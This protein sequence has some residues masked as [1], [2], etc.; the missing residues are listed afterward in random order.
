MQRS[1]ARFL[2]QAHNGYLC[3]CMTQHQLCCR[4]P[5]MLSTVTSP[6]L[7]HYDNSCR[8]MTI[9]CCC[10]EPYMLCLRV[11]N[12]AM[13][14]ASRARATGAL[15][16]CSGRNLRTYFDSPM[17]TSYFWG[18]CVNACALVKPI[19]HATVTAR[20]RRGHRTVTDTTPATHTAEP[21]ARRDD[22]Q[23]RRHAY[24]TERRTL[25][26]DS[27]GLSTRAGNLRKRANSNCSQHLP[28]RQI[29]MR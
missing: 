19:Q 20:Q 25:R 5:V 29:T 14:F 27:A 26:A 1:C 6:G 9:T 17:T 4:T 11:P 7:Q 21:K 10:H 13:Q 18:N 2:L 28:A 24:I 12:T 22:V 8:S 3:L 23:M 16:V 15:H